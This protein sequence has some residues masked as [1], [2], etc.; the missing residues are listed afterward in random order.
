[1]LLDIVFEI[2]KYTDIETSYKLVTVY[3]SIRNNYLCNYYIIFIK[4][5]CKKIKINLNLSIFN[6]KQLKNIYNS[7]NVLY[8]NKVFDIKFNINDIMTSLC[9]IQEETIL[10]NILLNKILS[11]TAINTN[12]LIDICIKNNNINKLKIIDKKQRHTNLI[13]NKNTIGNL[14]K[15]KQYKMIKLIFHLYLG[16]QINLKIYFTEIFNNFDYNNSE[17]LSL[18]KKLSTENNNKLFNY[19][20]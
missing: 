12:Y 14:M 9:S 1:M 4:K 3:P 13:I 11:I 17:C 6:L 15:T 20:L 18:C 10:F 7:L 2:I 5:Y 19:Y 16:E 8:K